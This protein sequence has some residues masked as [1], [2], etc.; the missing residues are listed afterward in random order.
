MGVVETLQNEQR[1]LRE[2]LLEIE[3]LLEEYRKWEE[4]AASLVGP[5]VIPR[6]EEHHEGNQEP[7][8]ASRPVT[9]MQDFEKAVIVAL[10]NAEKPKNRTDLL[11][12]LDAMD[13]VIGGKEPR[14][15]LSARL[16]RMSETVVNIT[17]HGYWLKDRPYDPAGYFGADDL[18][19]ER[20]TEAPSIALGAAPDEPT[21]AGEGVNKGSAALDVDFAQFVK[22]RDND[23][24]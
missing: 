20:E 9:S 15:T 11:A 23:L 8:T 6:A 10:S 2:R 12:D 14:N 21:S 13:I 16:T 3:Q 1:A 22:N 4:R 19:T 24:L 7:D 18:L 17:G 5:S